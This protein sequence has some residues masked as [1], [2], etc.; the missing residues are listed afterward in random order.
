MKPND[1]FTNVILP[2]LLLSF[3]GVQFIGHRRAV[4]N[5][6]NSLVVHARDMSK[7]LSVVVRSQGRFHTITKDRLEAA[8]KELVGTGQLLAVALQNPSGETIAAAGETLEE[9]ALSAQLGSQPQWT[10]QTLTL[11]DLVSLGQS[12]DKTGEG[13][14]II[15]IDRPPA[16][17]QRNSGTGEEPGDNAAG[18]GGGGGGG[19]GEGMG[20]PPPEPPPDEQAKQPDEGRRERMNRFREWRKTPE[21]QRPP[22]P[23]WMTKEEFDTTFAKQ[24]LHRFVM[25]LN[26]TDIHEA[27]QR[28][29]VLRFCLCAIAAA[30][31]LGLALWR[32]TLARNT[33]LQIRLARAQEMNQNLRDMNTAAAG[34]AHETRNPLNRIRG[35][36]QMIADADGTST[37]IHNRAGLIVE[38]VDRVAGRL[39]EFIEFSR[40]REPVIREVRLDALID[41]LLRTL[42]A[43]LQEK[44]IDI[45]IT[46]IDQRID[47]DENLLRRVLFNLLL[48]AIQASPQ[49]GHIQ[50]SGQASPEGIS[51]VVAD[52]GP[53]IPEAKREAIFH[54]YVSLNEQGTGLGLAIV[55]QIS[56]AHRW[57]IAVGKSDLGGAAFT[58]SGIRPSPKKPEN[59]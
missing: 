46:G 42:E 10:A 15:L 20:G 28:D 6:R 26:A 33:D 23:P 11:V 13:G 18:G 38:E 39:H 43:D 51:L 59:A 24:G 40:P 7:T 9:S 50:I 48:N 41:T 2:L 25:R 3:V 30:A 44:E 34:L 35:L 49:K 37:E 5:T 29:L 16:P 54:P 53:G 1:R 14:G 27:V 8:L 12:I 55:R 56:L 52:D 57:D 58:L 32:R 19:G 47:A 21:G 31:L 4:E 22:Y 45:K 17:P 36:S